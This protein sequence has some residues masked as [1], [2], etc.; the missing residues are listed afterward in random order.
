[1]SRATPNH[2]HEQEELHSGYHQKTAFHTHKGDNDFLFMNLKNEVFCLYLH[3]FILMCVWEEHLDHLTKTLEVL[4]Q[5]Q[6]F[7]KKS[8]C[9]FGQEQ[10]EC[11]GHLVFDEDVPTNPTKIV[12]M[13]SWPK[14]TNLKSLERISSAYPDYRKMKNQ[15][16]LYHATT[17]Y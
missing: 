1:M 15:L 4:G 17:I 12:V 10:I 16:T 6:L 14:P 13:L 5:H 2:T 11:L 3:P 8:K 7:V 9:S